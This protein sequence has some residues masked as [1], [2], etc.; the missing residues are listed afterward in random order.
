M[1]HQN[2]STDGTDS[3]WYLGLKSKPS[4]A[5]LALMLLL[6]FM[7]FSEL[8]IGPILLFGIW[9]LIERF[10][11]SEPV[12]GKGLMR[13]R[14]KAALNAISIV[15]LFRMVN[16][17]IQSAQIATYNLI[18]QAAGYGPLFG[19]GTEQSALISLYSLFVA[20]WLGYQAYVARRLQQIQWMWIFGSFAVAYLPF[21]HFFLGPLWIAVDSV[22]ILVLMAS[23]FAFRLPREWPEPAQ[24]SSPP[25][26]P[27]LESLETELLSLKRLLDQGL[28]SQEEYDAQKQNILR[29]HSH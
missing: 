28:L 3:H 15:L 20:G 17:F 12:C 27:V 1:T 2:P 29:K 5:F 23:I 13:N 16:L 26:L 22:L 11:P 14:T 7:M 9:Y 24:P 19:S 8:M 6:G 18:P 21:F 25:P 10:L 4:F